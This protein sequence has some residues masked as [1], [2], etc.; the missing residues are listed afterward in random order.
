MLCVL[1]TCSEEP[2]EKEDK[3]PP[4]TCRAS[5]VACYVA[6]IVDGE[7]SCLP[8]NH[9]VDAGASEEESAPME[10]AA[11]LTRKPALLQ[12]GAPRSLFFRPH[13][14]VRASWARAQDEPAHLLTSLV[15]VVAGTRLRD[16]VQQLVELSGRD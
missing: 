4:Y 12:R 10:H 9:G 2:V 3:P 6:D 16:C 1:A 13:P 11:G 7:P 15:I 5:E 8:A 14:V